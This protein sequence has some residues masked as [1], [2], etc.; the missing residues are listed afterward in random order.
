MKTLGNL[1]TYDLIFLCYPNTSIN[2][3]QSQQVLPVLGAVS[4]AMATSITDNPMLELPSTTQ[5]LRLSEGKIDNIDANEVEDVA[6]VPKEDIPQI[7]RL[8]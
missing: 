2:I 4:K 5:S 1:L 7:L 8:L 6:Q 3:N